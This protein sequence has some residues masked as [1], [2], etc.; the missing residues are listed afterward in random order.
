MTAGVKKVIL[1]VE[2]LDDQRPD[3][4]NVNS[5]VIVEFEDGNKYAATF[6][7]SMNLEKMIK[8]LEASDEFA[9][10]QSYKLL[11]IV[12]VKDFNNGDLT[13]VVDEMIAEGDFQLIFKKI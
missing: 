12:L 7:T 2:Y 4:Q 1:T 9:S 3:Y 5:D 10:G 11:N 6:F 13:P 8:D